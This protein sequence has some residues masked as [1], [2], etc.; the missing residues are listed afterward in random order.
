MESLKIFLVLLL[1]IT[2]SFVALSAASGWSLPPPPVASAGYTCDKHLAVCTVAGS[3]NPNYCKKMCM[4][5][6]MDNLN[7]G[8]C[9]KQC[10]SGKQC[11]KGKCVNIQTNRSN[12]GTCGY[13]CINTDHYCNGKCVNLKTD[14]LNCGS[15]GNKCGLNLNC[16]NWKIVNLHTNEKHCGRCQNNC[17]KDDACMNGICEYA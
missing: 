1:T 5:L 11:C 13:T 6:N 2:S 9:G 15:C 14:I 17:K 7:C 8:K 10:K 12:C 4:N 3:V 16:C